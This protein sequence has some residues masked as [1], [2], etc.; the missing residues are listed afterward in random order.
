LQGPDEAFS[1]RFLGK[2]ERQ[3]DVPDG[4]LLMKAEE[5]SALVGFRELTQGVPS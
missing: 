4:K 2:V 1:R 3:P 5:E